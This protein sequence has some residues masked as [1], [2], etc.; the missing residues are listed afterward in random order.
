M[1]IRKIV[2]M[3]E[4]VFIEGFKEVAGPIRIAA[5]MAVIYNPFAGK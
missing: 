2:T 1:K 3:V 4:E 5:S